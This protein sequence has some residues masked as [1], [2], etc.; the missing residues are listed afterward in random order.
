MSPPSPPSGQPLCCSDSFRSGRNE[1]REPR[2]SANSLRR[3]CTRRWTAQRAVPT[4][5][6]WRRDWRPPQT[7]RA[8]CLYFNIHLCRIRDARPCHT[9]S[10]RG[11]TRNRR[12]IS[13]LSTAKNASEINSH[14]RRSPNDCSKRFVIGRKDSCGGPICFCSCQIIC[15]HCSPFRRRVNRC[16]L[17][18]ANGRSGPPKNS[19]LFGSEI[20]SN[21]GCDGTKA[22]ATRRIT[23]CRIPSAGAWW[24]DP[25]NG[26]LYISATAKQH[27]SKGRDIALRCPRPR[28]EAGGMN[29]GNRAVRPTRCRNRWPAENSVASL[30]FASNRPCIA[31]LPPRRSAPAKASTAFASRLSPRPD[32]AYSLAGWKMPSAAPCGS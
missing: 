26:P 16:N 17:S 28:S 3:F 7:C 2:G 29:A 30:L 12:S 15:T 9:R 11:L 10:H 21:I 14:C 5:Q 8:H 32:C 31:A 4:S 19:A 18:S 6:T 13:S 20:S 24:R 1:R 25:K 22:V 27:P 23:F